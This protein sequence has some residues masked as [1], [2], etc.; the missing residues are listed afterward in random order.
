MLCACVDQEGDVLGHHR[1]PCRFPHF[2]QPSPCLLPL[3]PP[4]LPLPAP[5]AQHLLL[6]LFFSVCLPPK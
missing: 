5:K 3:A 4:H 6:L 2:P 1:Q